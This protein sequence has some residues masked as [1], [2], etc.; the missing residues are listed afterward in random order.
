MLGSASR[1]REIA[2]MFEIWQRACY[3]QDKH[4]MAVARRAID[5]AV[6][7]KMRREADMRAIRAT[8]ATGSLTSRL[9]SRPIL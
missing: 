1:A 2:R 6:G 9:L 3:M 4:M 8:F 7:G 5:A